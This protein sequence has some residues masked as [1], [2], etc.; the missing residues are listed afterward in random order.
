M[1]NVLLD[2]AKFLA[3]VLV[4]W[5]HLSLFAV[6]LAW[7]HFEVAKVLKF[8][9]P[10]LS[11]LSGAWTGKSASTAQVRRMLWRLALPLPMWRCFAPQSYHI[12][13]LII[14]SIFSKCVRGLPVTCRFVLVW[15]L[16]IAGVYLGLVVDPRLS[17]T[18]VLQAS[19]LFPYF[20]FGEQLDWR[21]LAQ[22]KTEIGSGFLVLGWLL[23]F[24]LILLSI[25][26]GPQADVVGALEAFLNDHYLNACRGPCARPF[27]WA[28][29]LALVGLRTFLSIF[30]LVACVPVGEVRFSERG[31]HTLYPA[32]LHMLPALLLCMPLGH[33]WRALQQVL[34]SLAMSRACLVICGALFEGVLCLLA[35]ALT[36]ALSAPRCRSCFQFIVEPTSRCCSKRQGAEEAKHRIND[37]KE[38]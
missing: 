4:T 17:S 34:S 21:W 11:I 8:H 32:L 29:Y 31:A 23:L 12:Q 22:R 38:E 28:R 9:V 6:G 33:M 36:Y 25:T 1:R 35:Y 2:N 5:H 10:L 20:F 27:L 18:F 30:F 37:G 14:W 24:G 26:L 3:I 19:T 7:P 16:G 13:I 15:V